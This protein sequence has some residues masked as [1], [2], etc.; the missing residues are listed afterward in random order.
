MR[1]NERVRLDTSQVSDR[2][3]GGIGLGRSV[4]AG[5][6]GIGLIIA[7]IIAVVF[8]VNPFEGGVPTDTGGYGTG[9]STDYGY[10]SG[11]SA[12]P[13]SGGVAAND[14][15]QE[16]QTGADANRR[17]DCRIV[18]IV[19]SIQ[20]YW[21]DEFARRSSR[22]TQA[23]TVL[24]SD[25]VQS[26]CGQATSAVGPFYCPLDQRVYIDLS[27]FRD[28][29]SRFGAQ[30]GPFAQAYVLAHEYGHHIQNEIGIL[31]R[32]D[33]RDTGPQ[34]DAVRSELMA[35]CL[36][37]VWAN[38][39]VATGYIA[40]LTQADIAQ[41]LDAAAAVGDDRIQ[42]SVQGRVTPENWTHGSAQ[43]RQRWF[44]QGYRS[45]DLNA[46]D[47]FSGPI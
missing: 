7:L 20:A 38:N 21:R 42:S 34:S 15:A 1:F 3:G 36:A 12:A 43:Q 16:C 46:C 31:D 8:G 13:G 39:A 45:G 32:L 44:L 40:E 29:Q 5:G 9:Y 17:E 4:A 23:R 24:F 30:G 6:G 19:N 41:G 33:R 14:L 10:G 18:G 11:G 22:Y 26:G 35:D 37:G 2:R 28:L 25:A 47:T 27:F